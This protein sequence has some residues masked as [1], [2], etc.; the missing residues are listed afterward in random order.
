MLE[1]CL[2]LRRRL[3]NPIDVAATLST[4]S[5]ARLQAGDTVGA[6][7]V[8]REALQIFRELG[9]RRGEAISLVHLAEIRAYLGDDTQARAHLEQCLAIA[10]EI[11]HQELEG[12]CELRYGEIAFDCG[13]GAQAEL[14]LKRSLTVCRECDLKGGDIMSARSRLSDALRAFRTFEMWEELLGCIEDFA[15]LVYLEGTADIAVRLSAAAAKARERLQLPRPPRAEE[16]WQS[17]LA[18]R[19]EVITDPVFEA[20]WSDGRNW[21]VEDAINSALATKVDTVVTA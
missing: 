8:E 14:W 10:R 3:G 11:K 2:L 12:V 4:L 7:E 16:R 6:G 19:R 21:D 1:R 5:P 18:S 17:Q 9:H 15:D 20:N 13:D